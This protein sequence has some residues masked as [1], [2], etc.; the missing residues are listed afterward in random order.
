MAD[1]FQGDAFQADAFQMG[2]AASFAQVEARAGIMRAGM[3]RAGYAIPNPVVTVNGIDRTAFVHLDTLRLSLGKNDQPSTATFTMTPDADFT[4]QNDE[5]VTICVGDV[6]N[7]WFGGQILRP[8]ARYVNSAQGD[9]LRFLDVECDDYGRAL[10]GHLVNGEYHHVSATVIARAIVAGS[11][12]RGDAIAPDLPTVDAVV[13][14]PGTTARQALT[15][16]ANLIGG[17][18]LFPDAFGVVHLW[19]PTGDVSPRAG[20]PPA[21]LTPTTPTLL[22]AFAYTPD[23]SQRRTR[24]LVEGKSTSVLVGT[25]AGEFTATIDSS[26][27]VDYLVVGGGAGGNSAGNH[28]G[29]G[30]GQVVIGTEVLTSG[31]YQVIVPAGGAANSNGGAAT[32]NAHTAPGGTA[33][34]GLN[35]G[36]SA[37][38]GGGGLSYGPFEAGGGGG[39]AAQAGQSAYVIPID[40]YFGGKGGDGV[41]TALAGS[42]AYYGGGGGGNGPEGS[43]NGGA[44]GGGRGGQGGNPAANGLPNT[45]GGGGGGMA[46]SGGSG[47]VYLSYP[48]GALAATGGVISHLGGRTIHAFLTPGTFNFV[49]ST[50][51][52]I[53]PPPVVKDL[54]IAD[55]LQLDANPISGSVDGPF[56]YVRIGPALVVPYLGLGGATVQPGSNPPGTTLRADVTAPL[57]GGSLPVTDAHAAGMT[58]PGWVQVGSDQFLRYEG[59]DGPGTSLTGIST[60][61]GAWGSLTV[62]LKSGTQVTWLSHI[63][64]SAD[65]LVLTNPIAKGAEV[66]QHV[67]VNDPV[68]QAALA[69]IDGTD[70]IREY[71]VSAGDLPVTGLVARGVAELG[72]FAGI[73][74][75]IPWETVDWNARP[76]RLQEFAMPAFTGTL[77]IDRV[78]VT[79]PA[80]HY[81]DVTDLTTLPWKRPIR[82]RCQASNI[83]SAGVL[84]AVSTET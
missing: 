72:A 34:S 44:G 57:A 45:G 17:G 9:P 32:F 76:G 53:A 36:G 75:S 41:Y 4:P 12:F 38:G 28:G 47:A 7:P 58:A 29:G 43:G 83:R 59:I 84:D 20:T 61:P 31:T 10:D 46:T 56:V 21:P 30:G 52:V 22:Q 2:G 18:G 54:P 64:L 40:R 65:G 63:N 24:A 5:R 78:D 16:L 35:G 70:G 33:G 66:V 48:E 3:A 60:I 25:P 39:G 23:G 26:A 6:S 79:F 27:S 19:G 74:S 55:A 11:G 50:V 49:V 77:T 51:T 62:P 37:L 82:L 42:P 73:T 8:V 80:T 69:A 1:A 13:F 15:T 71:Y 67:V 68:A 14:S 81:Q